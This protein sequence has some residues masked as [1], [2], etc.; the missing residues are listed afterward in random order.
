MRNRKT[1]PRPQKHHKTSSPKQ[2]GL[3]A[4]GNKRQQSARTKSALDNHFHRTARSRTNPVT[5]L[6][7]KDVIRWS[8]EDRSYIAIELKVSDRF[9]G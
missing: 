8:I 2:P 7:Q 5:H 1:A 6:D 4:K 9:V 3:I